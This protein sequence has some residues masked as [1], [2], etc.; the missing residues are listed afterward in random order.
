MRSLLP[1]L[2]L[3]CLS[4]SPAA[5]QDGTGASLVRIAVELGNLAIVV[6][7]VESAMSALF[8]WRVYRAAFNH[9]AL[10][11]PIM[12]A[13]G[14]LIV[15]LFR[16]D[17]FARVLVEVGALPAPA[18]GDPDTAG[19]G[20][21]ALISAM[22]IAGGTSGINTLFQTLGLRSNLPDAPPP[23]TLRQDEAWISIT[24]EGGAPGDRFLVA[25]EEGAGDGLPVVAGAV[26]VRRFWQRVRD[27]W[28]TEANRFPSYGG[29]TLKAQTPYRITVLDTRTAE[30]PPKL[31]FEGSFAPRAIVD[32][33]VRL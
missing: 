17:V 18:N 26:E 1:A 33:D 11:T 9:R 4:A 30:A 13:V 27:A 25:I 19:N 8:N 10:K 24:V 22:V 14:L 28:R 31:V 21:T 15:L 2:F 12:V 6:V 3:L 7:F 32:F 20:L 29:R 5:A 16:Y 23:P